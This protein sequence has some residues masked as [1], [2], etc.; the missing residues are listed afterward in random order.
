MT[1][2]MSKVQLGFWSSTE[3][4]DFCSFS[5]VLK[6]ILIN[7]SRFKLTPMFADFCSTNDRPVQRDHAHPGG[8]LVPGQPQLSHHDLQQTLL[9]GSQAGPHPRLSVPRHH[10]QLH[11]NSGSCLPGE[12]LSKENC[13]GA[14]SAIS[15][16]WHCSVTETSWSVLHP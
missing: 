13:N 10:E 3:K 6:F 7:A 8:H 5:S 11:P 1:L 9:R 16:R 12:V 2:S 14:S 15:A 4:G